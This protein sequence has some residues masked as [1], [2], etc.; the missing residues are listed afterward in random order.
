MDLDIPLPPGGAIEYVD[1]NDVDDV[2]ATVLME[3][4]AVPYLYRDG[5]WTNINDLKPVG[6]MVELSTVTAI[7]NDG[8]MVGIAEDGSAGWV[9]RLETTTD[10]SDTTP[11]VLALPTSFEVKATSRDGAVVFYVVTV[12]DDVDPNPMVQC[13]LPSGSLFTIAINTVNCTATDASGTRR[14]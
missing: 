14:A 5:T 8:T 2:V 4:F 6:N 13:I 1:V 7:N 9:L 3:N 11:P 12:S 10:P